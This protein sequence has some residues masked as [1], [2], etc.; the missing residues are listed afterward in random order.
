MANFVLVSECMYACVCDIANKFCHSHKWY[1]QVEM[2][3]Y[4]LNEW[5]RFVIPSGL[6]VDIHKYNT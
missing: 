3:V 5:Q 1:K 4:Q 6:K 2:H